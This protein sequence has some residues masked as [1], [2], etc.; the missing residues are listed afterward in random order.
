MQLDIEAAAGVEA[1]EGACGTARERPLAPRR[2]LRNPQSP[3]RCLDI[4]PLLSF[5]N[6]LFRRY[7]PCIGGQTRAINGGFLKY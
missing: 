3:P 5:Q 4:F 6:S 7:G 1:E 2:A